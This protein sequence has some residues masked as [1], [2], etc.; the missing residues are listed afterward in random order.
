MDT[1]IIDNDATNYDELISSDFNGILDWF[2]SGLLPCVGCKKS[3]G[4]KI[5]KE[6]I[7]KWLLKY[8][9]SF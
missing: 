9:Q 1:D 5:C 6:K 2:S 8:D 3:C 7:K 4:T